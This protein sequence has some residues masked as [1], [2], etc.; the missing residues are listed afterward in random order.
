MHIQSYV[1]DSLVLALAKLTLDASGAL[2]AHTAAQ[3]EAHI[4][5]NLL[6]EYS[7]YIHRVGDPMIQN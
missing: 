2:E 5:K 3:I 7:D 4:C 6:R 1:V